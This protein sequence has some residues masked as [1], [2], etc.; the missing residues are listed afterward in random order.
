MRE[1]STPVRVASVAS[2]KV[3]WVG[4]SRKSLQAYVI[5]P[6]V[7]NTA[8]TITNSDFRNVFIASCPVVKDDCSE[9]G[10]DPDGDRAAA[11]IRSLV[12]TAE[13]VPI[14]A[15][16]VVRLRCRQRR[17]EPR[18]PADGEQVFGL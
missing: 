6:S 16:R 8:V 7:V 4:T 2:S 13:L 11:G 17:I 5:A 12:D 18:V 15:D 1:P 14:V 9:L 3:P 10:R